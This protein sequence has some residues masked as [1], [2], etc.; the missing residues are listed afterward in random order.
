MK[1]TSVLGHKIC[2]NQVVVESNHVV[3]PG[4]LHQ[5]LERETGACIYI[6]ESMAERL[7]KRQK[8]T[9]WETMHDMPTLLGDSATEDRRA[10]RGRSIEEVLQPLL[11]GPLLP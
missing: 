3:L 11:G 9:A 2:P 10:C 5:C 4:L 1:K 8:Q 7:G 6:F